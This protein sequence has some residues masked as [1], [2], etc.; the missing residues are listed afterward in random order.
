M[1]LANIINA[2][3][4][5]AVVYPLGIAYKQNDDL[6]TACIA[7]VGI[8]S[9]YS[10]LFASHKHDQIGFGCSEKHSLLLN[11]LDVLGC[12][13]LSFRFLYLFKKFDLK[14]FSRLL[15]CIFLNILSEKFTISRFQYCFVHSCWHICI[16]H[17]MGL[18][19]NHQKN[20]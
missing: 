17:W 16:F 4:N 15:V 11:Q 10:H 2:F 12:F 5:I 1:S 6:T 18:F 20:D 13:V 9:F 8:F 7:I 14:L 19:L 3:S